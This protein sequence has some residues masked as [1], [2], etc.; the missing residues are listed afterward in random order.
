[1]APGSDEDIGGLDVAV[2]DARG[3]RG[4]ERIGDFDKPRHQSF[5]R[6]QS[7]RQL[8]FESR[9]IEQ[10]HDE[11]R[12]AVLFA[13]FVEGA[14]IRVVEGRSRPGFAAKAF[15]RLRVASELVRQEFDS[16]ERPRSRSSAL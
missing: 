4:V 10:F 2:D 13:N 3:V 7:L 5:D 9:A 12:A 14:N 15:E 6:Q 8:V 16:H 1:M 11:E